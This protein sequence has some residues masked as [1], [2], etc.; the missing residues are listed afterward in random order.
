M[1]IS[2]LGIHKSR[3][4][5]AQ[6]QVWALTSVHLFS[7]PG[8]SLLGSSLVPLAYWLHRLF[9]FLKKPPPKYLHQARNLSSELLERPFPG[10]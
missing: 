3:A 5:P 2:H 4:S 9:H 6:T 10:L 7:L 8:K 1:A